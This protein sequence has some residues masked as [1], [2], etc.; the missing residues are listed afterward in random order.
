MSDEN[1]SADDPADGE[2]AAPAKGW[3]TWSLEKKL[4]VVIIPVMVALIGVGVPLLT[5]VL[6]DE[7]G[8][9]PT[10]TPTS[11]EPSPAKGDVPRFSGVVGNF[12]Q[13]RA[14]VTFLEDN[15]GDPVQLEEVGFY[16]ATFDDFIGDP[17]SVSYVQVWTE[18]TPDIGAEVDPDFGMGCLATSF[19]IDG[20]ETA[21]T[22]TYLQHGVPVYDGFFRIDVS[23]NL[24]N[25]VSPIF[26]EP[27]VREDATAG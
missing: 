26:L 13:A 4:S 17:G 2:E 5:T 8:P 22:Q 15:D 3:S 24:Q 21:D 27:L 14:F 23:G 10:P 20:A 16:E 6:D 19:E 1:Q 18:C 11:V 9:L 7:S 12:E 25:G